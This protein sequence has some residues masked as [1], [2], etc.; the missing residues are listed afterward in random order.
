MDSMRADLIRGLETSLPTTFDREHFVA[1]LVSGDVDGAEEYLSVFTTQDSNYYSNL[2]FY[3]VKRQR[4]FKFLVEGENIKA[5]FLLIFSRPYGM[6]EMPIPETDEFISR[7]IQRIAHEGLKEWEDARD[8]GYT[9]DIL[10]VAK[11]FTDE[12]FTMMNQLIPMNPDLHKK[13]EGEDIS[14]QMHKLHLQ[15]NH[16]AVAFNGGEMNK[17]KDSPKLTIYMVALLYVLCAVKLNW[18]I[19]LL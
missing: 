7:D 5:G 2:M 9:F 10:S 3:F 12:M 13:E 11:S 16:A 17:D 1:L 14:S 4:F 15:D 19:C 18:R 8:N 6:M